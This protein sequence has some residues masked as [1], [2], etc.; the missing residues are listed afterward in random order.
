M[1]SSVVS[2]WVVVCRCFVISSIDSSV[3]LSM[4][5][6]CCVLFVVVFSW[7]LLVF[8]MVVSPFC[9]VL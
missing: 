6:V 8:V 5:S 7:G 9:V 1:A 2:P 3:R 4:L